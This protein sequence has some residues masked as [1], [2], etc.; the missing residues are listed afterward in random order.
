M[1]ALFTKDQ[2]GTICWWG[3]F[4]RRFL[5]HKDN[6]W[7]YETLSTARIAR[8]QILHCELEIQ[9]FDLSNNCLIPDSKHNPDSSDIRYWLPKMQDAIHVALQ[10]DLKRAVSIISPLVKGTDLPSN[11]SELISRTMATTSAMCS[12]LQNGFTEHPYAIDKGNPP[13]NCTAHLNKAVGAITAPINKFLSVDDFYF[14]GSD[15]RLKLS[16]PGRLLAKAGL[17]ACYPIEVPLIFTSNNSPATNYNQIKLPYSLIWRSCWWDIELCGGS[18]ESLD[19]L[20]EF[21]GH[22]YREY[23]WQYIIKLLQPQSISFG[24]STFD[25]AS[26]WVDETRSLPDKLHVGKQNNALWVRCPAT[27]KLYKSPRIEAKMYSATWVNLYDFLGWDNG[28]LPYELSLEYPNIQDG[29]SL[30]TN[31]VSGV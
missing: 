22:D 2:Q 16:I 9:V 27:N 18:Y 5:S 13:S 15:Y 3:G 4:T 24:K 28:F 12:R 14:S 6:A 30:L 1:Y 8:G 20:L 25:S 21:S 17:D 31:S 10:G 23:Q 29:Y 26:F 7:N 11:P 19:Q